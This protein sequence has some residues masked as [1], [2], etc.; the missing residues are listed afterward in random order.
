MKK[1]WLFRLL[2]M[3]LAAILLAVSVSA[4]TVMSEDA[5][6]TPGGSVSTAIHQTWTAAK[7]QIQTVV[8]NVVFPVLD[9]ILVVMLF[10]KI[11]TAFFDYRKHGQFDFTAPGI[12]FAC[13]IFT[14]TAPLYIWSIL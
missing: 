1:R 5:G 4:A 14:L 8:D 12:L 3:I 7:S 9:M 13:L 2:F 6:T 10:V 11:S